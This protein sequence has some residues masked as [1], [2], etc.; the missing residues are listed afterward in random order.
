MAILACHFC[1]EIPAR[2]LIIKKEKTRNIF[3]EVS[4]IAESAGPQLCDAL[5][6]LHAVTRCDSTS[7]FASKG[8]KIALKLCEIDPMAC[9]GMALLGRS[10]DMEAVPF[11][12]CEEFICKMYGRPDL[13]DVNECRY[14]LFCTKQSQSQS[15]PPCQDSVR[16]HILRAN[17]QAA[18]WRRALDAIPGAPSPEGHG[19]FISDGHLEIDWMSL[20]FKYVDALQTAQL[21]AACAREM[22]CHTQNHASAVINV[23][24]LTT[25]CWK[26]KLR[27]VMGTKNR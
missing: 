8:K 19:W 2:L 7:A 11:S 16:N 24:T 10:F 25:T 1:S 9:K 6:G 14:V 21:V 12:D 3:L 27:T 15:L 13:A 22:V 23:R 26:K 5:P 17:C 4:D 20:A 18:V